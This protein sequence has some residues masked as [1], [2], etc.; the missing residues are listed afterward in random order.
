MPADFWY[1]SWF[2]KAVCSG[3]VGGQPD[4]QGFYKQKKEKK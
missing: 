1:N 4:K 2:T 3:G